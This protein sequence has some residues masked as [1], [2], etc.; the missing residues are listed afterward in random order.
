M[1]REVTSEFTTSLGTFSTIL[2]T[3]AVGW[4]VQH[5]SYRPVFV[6][7]SA[8]SLASYIVV[9]LILGGTGAAGQIE[10]ST[11]DSRKVNA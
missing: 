1:L 10:N 6:L 2:F 3:A 7:L 11:V 4:I 8:L 9:L 5:Y